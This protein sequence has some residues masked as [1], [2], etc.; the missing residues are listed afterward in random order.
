MV[1]NVQVA[2]KLNKLT[3]FVIFVKN[4]E[5][6]NGLNVS[7]IFVVNGYINIVINIFKQRIFLQIIINNF[8]F[9]H[10]VVKYKKEKYY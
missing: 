9:V 6:A 3:K 1:I 4:K 2:I 8:I 10:F 7:V 5:M